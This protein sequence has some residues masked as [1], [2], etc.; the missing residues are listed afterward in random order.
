MP[1]ID[2]IKLRNQRKAIKL[3]QEELAAKLGWSQPRLS[4]Y[5]GEDLNRKN[6]SDKDALILAEKLNCSVQD[7]IVSETITPLDDTTGFDPELFKLSFEATSNAADKMGLKL[8][9]NQKLNVA[10]R[11]YTENART[12]NPATEAKAYSLLEFVKS[13]LPNQQII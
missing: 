8:D 11:L 12:G 1:T 3:N 6:I 13:F 10:I 4:Y 9:D 2:R 5:E 7:I